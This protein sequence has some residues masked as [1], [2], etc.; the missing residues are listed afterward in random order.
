LRYRVPRTTKLECTDALKVF[1]FQVNFSTDFVIQAGLYQH[2]RPAGMTG[3]TVSGAPDIIKRGQF[4]QA[5]ST[6]SGCIRRKY[7]GA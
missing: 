1:T 5:V 7:N 4:H 3:Q 2:W 6:G